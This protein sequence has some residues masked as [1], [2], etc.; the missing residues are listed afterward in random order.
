MCV[1]TRPRV[2]I[3]QVKD[4]FENVHEKWVDYWV[5]AMEK[6]VEEKKGARIAKDKA[7]EVRYKFHFNPLQF[8]SH[9]RRFAPLS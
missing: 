8:E 5:T 6:T 2:D 9:F 3:A 4:P 7:P 1:C